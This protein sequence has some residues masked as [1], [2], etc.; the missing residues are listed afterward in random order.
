MQLHRRKELSQNC[1]LNQQ[2]PSSR[3]T[4]VNSPLPGRDT[5]RLSYQVQH[6]NSTN[7]TIQTEDNGNHRVKKE[8]MMGMKAGRQSGSLLMVMNRLSDMEN[9]VRDNFFRRI[10]LG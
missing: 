5:T 8:K 2:P 10:D 7:P 1:R 3:W 4:V 9:G 6:L